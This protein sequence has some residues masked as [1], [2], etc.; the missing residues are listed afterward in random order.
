MS[1]P[2]IPMI[3]IDADCMFTMTVLL[4]LR[5]EEY[6]VTLNKNTTLLFNL[7]SNTSMH[8]SKE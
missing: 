2:F 7:I 6:I 3:K 4:I 5:G 8:Q 1:L